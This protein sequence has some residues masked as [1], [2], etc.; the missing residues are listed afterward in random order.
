MVRS[1]RLRRFDAE[2]FCVVDMKH[3]L[4]SFCP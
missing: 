3:R 1:E 4:S 2:Y